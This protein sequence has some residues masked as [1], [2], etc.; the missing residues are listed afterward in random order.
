MTIF[1]STRRKTQTIMHRDQFSPFF[2]QPKL[3]SFL[4]I[5]PS[6]RPVH[7]YELFVGLSLQ[8]HCLSTR[9]HVG[10]LLSVMADRLPLC[11]S[12]FLSQISYFEYSNKCVKRTNENFS[13]QIRLDSLELKSAMNVSL[14]KNKKHCQVGLL[15]ADK[16]KQR[17]QTFWLRFNWVYLFGGISKY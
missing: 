2:H 15:I 9:N 17:F 1:Y 5:W 12:V 3:F 16:K 13:S 4:S 10:Q 11:I 8:R 6:S 7:L 14:K